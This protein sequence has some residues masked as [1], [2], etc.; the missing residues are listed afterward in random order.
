MISAG[1]LDN[2]SSAYNYKKKQF[3]SAEFNALKDKWT[4]HPKY[5]EIFKSIILNL[6]NENP[7]KRISVEDLY[8]FVAKYESSIKAKEQF[9]ITHPPENLESGVSLVR[10]KVLC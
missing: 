6:V 10:S 7:A 8:K 5:S 4:E 9:I 1:L 2:L 3:N